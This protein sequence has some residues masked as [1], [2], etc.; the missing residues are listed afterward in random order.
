MWMGPTPSGVYD[1]LTDGKLSVCELPPPALCPS[2]SAVHGL[3]HHGDGSGRGREEEGGGGVSGERGG[4]LWRADE[5]RLYSSA[6]RQHI[7]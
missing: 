6:G 7:K 2:L 5:G 3:H 4:V 1:T